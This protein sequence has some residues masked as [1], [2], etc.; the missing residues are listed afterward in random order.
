MM[1]TTAALPPL[2]PDNKTARFYGRLTILIA[3][4]LLVLHLTT[5]AFYAAR[6]VLQPL[7]ER[8]ERYANDFVD[9]QVKSNTAALKL[10]QG[11]ATTP[12]GKAKADAAVANL[13]QRP[14]VKINSFSLSFS[15][16]E[17]PNARLFGIV[18]GI[19]SLFLNVAMLWGA[20]GLV[21]LRPWG[22]RTTW[23]VCW[24]KLAMI[25]LF[26]IAMMTWVLPA[27]LRDMRGQLDKTFMAAPGGPPPPTMNPSAIAAMSTSAVV[28]YAFLAMIYPI[29]LLVQ[30]RKPRVKAA[31]L[32]EVSARGGVS[33][34]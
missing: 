17:S 14:T 22:Y 15:A 10:A 18:S 2:L 6:P 31:C 3:S 25:A 24:I 7:G 19:V 16:T 30:L 12:A 26:G 21:S 28:F 1:K 29:L 9:S 20:V 32:Q 23:W 4:V 8:V 5:F 27:Q 33:W 13:K 11:A 34:D